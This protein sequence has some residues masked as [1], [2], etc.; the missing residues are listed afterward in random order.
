MNRYLLIC[1]VTVTLTIVAGTS[2]ADDFTDSPE[3]KAIKAEAKAELT[4]SDG[5][6][7]V[8]NALYNYPWLWKARS[9]SLLPT[10]KGVSIKLTSSK[11]DVG[12]TI[13]YG[14][15]T[16]ADAPFP[17]LVAYNAKQQS[18]ARDYMHKVKPDG[19]FE[20]LFRDSDVVA[21]VRA[22]EPN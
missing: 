4:N 15:L 19:T 10:A 7:S 22:V 9:L 11:R 2:R 14:T 12:F 3:L 13:V 1:A 17:G 21:F 8:D 6:I 20:A 5:S 18:F 16:P